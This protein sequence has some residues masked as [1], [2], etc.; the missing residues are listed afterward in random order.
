LLASPTF[1]EGN[2]DISISPASHDFGTVNLE[3]SSSQTFTISN[4]GDADLGI[5]KLSITGEN[6]FEFAIRTAD[7]SNQV[8]APAGS[9]KVDL[10]FFPNIEGLKKATFLIPSNDPDTPQLEV[11]LTGTSRRIFR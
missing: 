4:S 3:A 5:G 11:S 6:F 10:V 1:T 9:C 7:C 8:I 2:P